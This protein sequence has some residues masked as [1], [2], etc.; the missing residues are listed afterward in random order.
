MTTTAAI[1]A[2]IFEMAA[3]AFAA[4]VLVPAIGFDGAC[5]ASP[6]AWVAA[7]IFLVSA[8]VYCRKTLVRISQSRQ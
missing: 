5:L 4:V 7:D 8:F 2:G 1:I 6:L 3:R